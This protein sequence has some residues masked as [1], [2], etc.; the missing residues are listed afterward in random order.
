MYMRV[1]DKAHPVVT[2]EQDGALPASLDGHVALY[3]SVAATYTCPACGQHGHTPDAQ[4]D[5]Q[6]SGRS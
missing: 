3:H 1:D 5:A 6:R 4:R 2:L